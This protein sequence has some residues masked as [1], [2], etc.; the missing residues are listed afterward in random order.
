M[1]DVNDYSSAL[2]YDYDFFLGPVNAMRHGHPLLVDT[3][4][5]YGVGM[6]YALAAAFH[7]V[8]LTYGGLQFVLCLAYAAEFA[9]VYTVLRLRAALSSSPSSGSPW[10]WS[11]TSPCH[12]RRT[13]RIPARG[14]FASACPGW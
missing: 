1:T 10:H 2:R 3:F 12:C 8:P 13:S 11:R 4:S 9:L 7:G 14:R 6:F 5:Q